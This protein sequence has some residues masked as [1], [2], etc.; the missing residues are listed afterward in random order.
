MSEAIKNALSVIVLDPKL[1]AI[2]AE[3]DPKAFAQACAALESD[4]SPLDHLKAELDPTVEALE[5]KIDTAKLTPF[6]F[7]NATLDVPEQDDFETALAAFVAALQARSDKHYA[8]KFPNLDPTKYS[9]DPRGKKYKRIVDT[10]HGGNR[11]VH[12]FVEVATGDIW[13]AASWKA[14]AKNFPRGNIYNDDPIKGTNVYG[15]DYAK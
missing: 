12:C 5:E 8:E 7:S 4:K 6:A 13:K 9:V 2:L 14:P 1:S 3:T 11:S 15:A 10:T